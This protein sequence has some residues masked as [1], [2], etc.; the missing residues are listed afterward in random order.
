MVK[1]LKHVLSAIDRLGYV[2][3]EYATMLAILLEDGGAAT[4][5]DLAR[6]FRSFGTPLNPEERKALGLHPNALMTCEAL[7]AL[8]DLGRHDPIHAFEATLQAASWSYDRA[9]VTAGGGKFM[10]EGKF[11]DCRGCRRLNGQIVT[12]DF[13]AAIPPIDCIHEACALALKPQSE[14]IRR[15]VEH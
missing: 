3:Q 4:P 8:T 1:Y 6:L 13:L 7:A 10:V 5:R 11:G 14:R 9:S 15:L 2:R 12:R